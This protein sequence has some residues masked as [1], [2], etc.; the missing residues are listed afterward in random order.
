MR[1]SV[2]TLILYEAHRCIEPRLSALRPFQRKLAFWD[3]AVALLKQSD[4]LPHQREEVLWRTGSS[5]EPMNA[6]TAWKRFKLVQKEIDVLI[7]EKISPLFSEDKTH[8]ELYSEFVQRQFEAVSGQTGKD[9]PN[10][11]EHSHNNV[12]MAY[13]L[14]YDGLKPDPNFPEAIPPVEINVP[15]DKPKPNVETGGNGTQQLPVTIRHNTG[16]GATTASSLKDDGDYYNSQ[17]ECSR[18]RRLIL[19]EIK[20]HMELLDKFG[21]VVPSDVI[22]KRKRD[23]FDLLPPV[24]PS[25]Q[26]RKQKREGGN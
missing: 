12:I 9:C 13:K 3:Q 24:P 16:G 20:Q 22:K 1:R 17:E 21:G 26:A 11:W 6:E 2:Q 8:K 15:H 19:E 4:L 7:K 5:K 10:N 23:L 14:Y 18:E 25:F